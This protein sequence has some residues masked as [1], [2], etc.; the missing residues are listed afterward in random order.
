VVVDDRVR[1]V[2]ADPGFGAHPV[3][4]ALGAIAG[5][6]VPGPPEGVCPMFCVGSG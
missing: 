2:V 5:R 1:V 3:P 6:A 4:V